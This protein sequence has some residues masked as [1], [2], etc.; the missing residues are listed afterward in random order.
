MG[1]RIAVLRKVPASMLPTLAQIFAV[2]VEQLLGMNSQAAKR[3]PAPK[4]VRQIEQ[5]RRLP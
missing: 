1:Q 3:G 2:P 5:I 4:L